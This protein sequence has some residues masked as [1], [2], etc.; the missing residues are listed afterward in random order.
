MR[1]ES[2]GNPGAGGNRAGAKKGSD[3][4]NAGPYSPNEPRSLAVETQSAAE[5]E[6]IAKV[7][8]QLPALPVPR[9]L[10][11]LNIPKHPGGTALDVWRFMRPYGIWAC[12]DG[13][14]VLFNRDYLPIL[15]RYPGQPCHAANPREW[16]R[17]IKQ[18]WLY[19]DGTPREQVAARIDFVLALWGLP[20]MP[21]RPTELQKWRNPCERRK[22]PNP[23]A[24][25]LA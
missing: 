25:V 19:N 17:W 23:W 12:A 18:N 20:P 14:Q 22:Q 9:I 24:R 21:P 13:R 3:G 2:K 10:V 4:I 1:R 15:E 16:V 8:N 11:L 5:R 6:F 7:M